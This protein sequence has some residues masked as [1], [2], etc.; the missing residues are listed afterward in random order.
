[1]TERAVGRPPSLLAPRRLGPEEWA[2]GALGVVS[3]P[4]VA[5]LVV[6]LVSALAGE[7]RVGVEPPSR[8]PLA[9]VQLVEARFVRKGRRPDANRMPNRRVPRKATAPRDVVA[10]R[11]RLRGERRKQEPR[12]PDAAEDLIRRL[13]DRAQA[14][15]EIAE[16]QEQEGDPGGIAEGTESEAREGDLYAGKL[17]LFFRRGWSVPTVIDA[18]RRRQL[19]TEVDVQVAED[20]RLVGARLRKGSGEPLFDQS[21]LDHLERLRAQGVRIPEPPASVEARYRGRWIGLRFRGR[22]AR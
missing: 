17:Y 16:E 20:L 13:G 7:R 18:A 5:L 9:E 3:L 8:P 15:A 21:V 11:R 1:M 10:A 19:V 4:S 6:L 2:G 22:D 12:R 14:F